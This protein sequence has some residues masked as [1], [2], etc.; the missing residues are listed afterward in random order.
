MKR[1]T[2]SDVAKKANVSKSTVSQYV[3]NRF[4]YMSEDT[5]QKIK[6]VIDELEY[7]VNIVARSLT[8]KRTSTIGIIVAN[9]L[10]SFSTQVIRAVEDYYNNLDIHVIVCNADDNSLKERKYIEM[11][12][13]KQVDGLIVFPT[14]GNIDLFD[15]LLKQNYPLVFM[16]R[17]IGEIN[18]DTVLLDN[19]HAS[20][21]AV[22]H[23][24]S[25]GHENI[26]IITTSI[27]KNIT[28]RVERIEGYKSSLIEN[29]IEI[30]DSY[31]ISREI[32]EIFDGI[33]ELMSLEK[34]PTAIYAGNDLSLMEVL[35]YVKTKKIIIPEELSIISIDNVSYADIFTP[36]LTIISQ[37]SLK[38]A[39][40][41][42]ELLLLKIE[43]KDNKKKDKNIYKFEGDLLSRESVKKIQ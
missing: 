17:K 31:I 4:E 22:N 7:Q 8:Q 38:M 30:N 27:L 16:D 41:A 26:A 21:L 42:S 33:H 12:M 25:K 23:L 34:P 11:L 43:R 40:K 2:M 24:T 32:D 37:P 6:E 5:K 14:G 10:H 1:V 9:I 39:E 28:P 36:R 29:G 15:S 35:K 20:W 3:N 18:V 19:M 13:A